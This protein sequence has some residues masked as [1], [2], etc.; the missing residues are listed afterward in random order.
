MLDPIFLNRPFAHRGLWNDERPE[1]S[2]G[3]IVAAAKAGFGVELD[4]Q[5]SGDE[6]AMVFHDDTLDRLTDH[7]GW[8]AETDSHTLGEIRLASTDETIPTFSEVLTAVAGRVP[9]LVELKDQT[10][11]PGGSLG[12]LETRVMRA[13]KHYDG[14]VAVMSFHPGMVK[15]ISRM[16]PDTPRGL[17]GM[18]FDPEN[19]GQEAADALNDYAAFEE[20]GSCFVSHN[21]RD[22]SMPA[23]SRLKENG[24]PILCWTVRAKVE[25]TFARRIADNVTFEGYLPT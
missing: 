11:A 15:N 12:P 14:P 17:T 16:A 9:L 24:V 20:T 8:V 25:E 18:K 6:Q 21:W 23:V 13:L 3:A 7:P 1:N 4:L 10:V 5:L 19:V 22:L 2:L